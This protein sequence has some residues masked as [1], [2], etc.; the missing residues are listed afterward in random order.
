MTP[1]T[2]PPLYQ[3]IFAIIGVIAII[4]LRHYLLPWLQKEADSKATED[5]TKAKSDSSQLDQ[6]L[7]SESDKLKDIEGR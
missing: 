2:L 4:V 3:S 7:N 6:S 5:S 1:I